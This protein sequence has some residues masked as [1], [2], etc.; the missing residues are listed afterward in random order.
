[1]TKMTKNLKWAEVGFICCGILV[2]TA[3]AYVAH[4]RDLTS[5]ES[6]LLQIVLAAISIGISFC[7]GRRWAQYA[8]KPHAES[9]V[10]R[11]STLCYTLY[12]AAYLIHSSQNL[13]SNNDYQVLLARLGGI[14]SAQLPAAIDAVKD[15]SD[16]VP[17]DVAAVVQEFEPNN[18]TEENND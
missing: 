14:I 17:E 10:R 3:I 9:A 8:A 7:V 15:W 6:V 4:R 2:L 11:L 1:M 18:T 13:R 5:L 16:F 12:S